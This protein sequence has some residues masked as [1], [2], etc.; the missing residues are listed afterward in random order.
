MD[1]RTIADE[2]LKK[3]CGSKPMNILQQ[4]ELEKNDSK[5]VTFKFRNKVFNLKVF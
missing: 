3:L 1:Y 5:Y 2:N 4:D